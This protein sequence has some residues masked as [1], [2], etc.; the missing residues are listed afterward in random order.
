MRNLAIVVPIRRTK[1]LNFFPGKMIEFI[2]IFI[3]AVIQG[4][5]EFL[6]ISSSGHNAVIDHLYTRSGHPMTETTAEFIKLDI[7]VHVGSLI[8]ILIVFR[9]R[10]I[11]LLGK[12]RRLI[13]MLVVAT[14]PVGVTGLAIYF[15]AP[16][17]KDNMLVISACFVA[18]GIL[19]LITIRRGEGE[20][21]CSTMTWKDAIIIGCVQGV[22][23]LPGLSRSGATIVAGLFCGLKREEA[24]TF[25]FL[26]AIPAIAGS[27]VVEVIVRTRAAESSAQGI[28]DW[29]LIFA[30]LISCVTGVIALIFLLDWLKKGKLWY[31]A[32][33]VFMMAL[34]T[35]V[36][37]ALPI[38]EEAEAAQPPV[39]V[40]SI[41][42][43]SVEEQP[44]ETSGL[45]L[46]EF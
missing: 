25:S 6:P 44:N 40:Q 19:L 42:V 46:D 4:I 21:T 15:F 27:G 43:Q 37:A 11:D 2:Q 22:A 34:V 29:L 41:E 10:I 20:K 7:M 32:I 38:P 31:F 1:L 9:Q 12:D 36:L 13:P 18:T 45:I 23:I 35:L 8:A 39:E 24:A 28:P 5:T 17:V 30:G 14:I 33:W 3:F 16:W 26:L